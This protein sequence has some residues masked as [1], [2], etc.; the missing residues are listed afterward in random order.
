LVAQCG[1]SDPFGHVIAWARAD[2][3]R[4]DAGEATG[5]ACAHTSDYNVDAGSPSM[6]SSGSKR[7]AQ[8]RRSGEGNCRGGR[9][10]ESGS[11]EAGI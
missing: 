1:L 4:S 3:D 9:P 6:T 7:Q 11:D 8:I 5:K 10:R 2:I